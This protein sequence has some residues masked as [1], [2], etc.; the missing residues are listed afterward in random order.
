LIGCIASIFGNS[1]PT[2]G[3][4]LAAQATQSSLVLIDGLQAA[5]LFISNEFDQFVI[6]IFI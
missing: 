3:N 6:A 2:G 4:G 1:L 5:Q